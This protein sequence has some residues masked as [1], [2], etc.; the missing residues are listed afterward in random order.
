MSVHAIEDVRSIISEA[1]SAH[2]KSVVVVF[3][4]DNAPNCLS[5]AGLPQL[6][7]DQLQITKGHTNNIIIAVVHK[8]VTCPTFNCRT[9]QTQL[10]WKDWLAT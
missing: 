7:F 6:Y 9:L 2:N 3:T 5:A 8:A 1:R 10:D 4:K